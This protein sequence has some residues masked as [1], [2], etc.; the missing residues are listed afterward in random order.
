MTGTRGE[1]EG[2]GIPLRLR[3]A[4]TALLVLLGLLAG[5]G[6]GGRT[7][8]AL[9]AVASPTPAPAVEPTASRP[10]GLS[11]DEA[12]TLG[13]L[14]QVDDYPLYTMH[15]SGSYPEGMASLPAVG[16]PAAAKGPTTLAWSCA[17]FATL[18]DAGSRLYGRNFDWEFS[19]ALLLYTDPADGY[20]SVSMVDIAYLIDGGAVHRLM[21]L[22]LEARR[23]LLEAPLWPF[24]GM[25]EHGVAVGM[26]AVPPGQMVSDRAKET[27]GSLGIIRQILDHARN[28]DDAVSLFQSHNVDME[29]GP[30]LHYL[31]AD[32]SGRSV[33]VEFYR[34]EMVLLPNEQPWQLA[35]NFLRASVGESAQDQCWRYDRISDELSRTEGRLSAGG[36]MG[37]LAQ[38]AQENT[39]WSVA[40]GMST[41]EVQVVMGQK[42]K[43]PHIFPL[44]SQA[45]SL[46]RQHRSRLLFGTSEL[47]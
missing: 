29:G 16:R 5:C 12:T 1:S 13:S 23:G 38:V 39:Q 36:A 25:N 9:L 18:G 20:A 31:I 42:Y 2:G 22:P 46:T 7:P 32:R 47:Q 26:A 37:L 21:D 6:T 15:Y 3:Y 10:D 33:L 4:A 24:D 8:T 27:I 14:E 41:G 45:P 28:V 34:G 30:P 19:P 17:L 43:S 11:A 44:P 35:T 40:Y